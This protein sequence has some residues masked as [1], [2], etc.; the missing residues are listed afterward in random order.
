MSKYGPKKH[1]T[2]FVLDWSS[3]YIGAARDA[4]AGTWVSKH[5]WDGLKAGVVKMSPYNP[6]IPKE[7]LSHVA[8]QER[9]IIAGQLHPFSGPIRDQDGKQRVAAGAALPDDQIKGI[10][11]FVEGMQ[12]NLPKG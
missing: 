10:N 7:V 12:G 4:M 6:A 3:D 8:E 9:A 1:L 5:R 2:S 11:W